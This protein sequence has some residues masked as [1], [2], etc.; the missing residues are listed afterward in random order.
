LF[1][2]PTAPASYNVDDD[3][4]PGPTHMYYR[5]EKILGLLYRAIDEKKIWFENIKFSGHRRVSVFN[6][7]L[8]HIKSECASRLGGISVASSITEKA[9]EIRHA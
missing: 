9:W 3:E 1:D 7:L 6:G 8:N 2:A 4:D 5:S